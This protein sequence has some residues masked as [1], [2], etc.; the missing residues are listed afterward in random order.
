MNMNTTPLEAETRV[1][2]DRS[3][4]NLGWK[5][6]GKD[7]NVFFEQPKTELERKK[8]G[9]KRPDYVLYSKERE[10]PLIVIEAKK[11]GSRIDEAL[12]QGIGYARAIDAPLVFATDGVFCKAF[13]TGA[14]RP[15]ILNGE[16]IDEFIREALALRYL[17]SYEVNTVSPKVQ[18]DR[19][20]LIRIFD[21]A[22]NMLR[23]EGL[24]AG[25][26]RFGEFANILFL[27]LISESEQAK[28][29]RGEPTKF[30]MA[31]SWDAIK[32]I[33]AST[34]IEYIN[35][36]V[37]NKLNALY[38]TD[39]F[40]P[41]QIKDT[42]ILK[43]IM[44][45]LDPLMLTDV[46]SDV[47]GDAFE[48]FLKASTSTK[49]DLG[50]YFTPRHIVKTMVR[51]VNPQIGEK[52]YDPFCGTGGFLIESFRHIYNNMARTEANLKTL[53][54]KTVYGHEITNTARITKMNMILAGDGHSNIEMKD[55]LANPIDGT[56]TYTDENGVVHHNGF[57]IVL[58]N[59]P[60]SQ[61][62]KHGNLYD[63]PSTNG[64][65]ICVQHCMKA[66]NSTSENG[67]MA[68]VVPE[69][70]LFRKDLTKTREY[71]L[72]NCQLQSIISLPQ[73]V[74]LPY[75][76]VKTDIIYA[77]KVNQKIKASERRKDFWYFDV[78]SDGYTLDNHRRKLDTPSDLSKY[79]EY[80][81][82]D[83]DQIEN[84]LKVGFEIIPLD[85]VHKNSNIFVGS[86]YREQKAIISNYEIV[87]IGDVATLVSG[88]GFPMALQGQVGTIPFYKV[89]D[90][91]SVGNEIE[92]HDSRNY[93]SI[94]VAQEQKWIT[95]P[96]GTVIFPKIGAAIATNKKRILSEP[97]MF[98]NNVMGIICSERIMPRFMWYV[99]N[100]I[101]ISNWAT[102]ANPPSISKDIVLEQR[103]PLPPLEAQQQIVSELDGYQQIIAGARVVVSNYNPV[104]STNE[105]WKT[106]T[107]GDLFEVV[108]DTVNPANETGTVDY[109]GLENIESGTGKII[110]KLECD[111]NTIK[112]TKRVFKNTDILFG[113][114]RPALNKVAFPNKN[115]ICSTDIIILRSKSKDT[116]PEFY[117][118]LLRDSEFNK[119]VLNGVS[120]GQLPRVDI[121]YLLSLP[122]YKVPLAEQTDVLNKVKTE[123]ELTESTEKLISIFSEKIKQKIKK[124]WGE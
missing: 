39:I 81:K 38:E 20:E 99:L 50:E 89:G 3:L 112:S 52:I 85:K 104:I 58:A 71:L 105:M 44:D 83:K 94:E 93:V 91:N 45:K 1:L 49:N 124:V 11:K 28:K 24:R 54:E 110:G 88:Y 121:S 40:T 66:I 37:Y 120:G 102:R 25:I 7:K 118:I 51:L 67:R 63:L 101:D 61:K 95:S 103:I 117:S 13:H 18:Y 35:K 17:T 12:E 31:C 64:D 96:K 73:G 23:G 9:G 97:A 115:G 82:F 108:T 77:T 26:E 92:M 2:I 32:G 16:E 5:F 47:K 113:K 98:D 87:T 34:R 84:M 80:R 4:E 8:L 27:K 78:K 111:I 107:V 53:R 116:L 55:S 75:T 6:K 43:D 65:S 123:K 56:S 79:E 76:G 48:Y 100:S 74:F 15:P 42:G 70:F 68:L 106:V 86:R 119:Q 46:D 62:T 21:E 69:G 30:D 19:K 22:N 36:T 60:Y 33:P 72:E 114:L 122:I 10:K 109:V 29:E 57:D 41:L 90:M 59:M 14:N